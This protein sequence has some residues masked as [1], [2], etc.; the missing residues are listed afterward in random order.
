RFALVF[1][2]L[3]LPPVIN[4]MLFPVDG[5]LYSE[6]IVM[7][8]SHSSPG[9]GG[10]INFAV[11]FIYMIVMAALLLPRAR[12][13][14]RPSQIWLIGLVSYILWSLTIIVVGEAT[15]SWDSFS[16]VPLGINFWAL[17]VY[18]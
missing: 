16:L 10:F 8:S 4:V 13:K 3:F 12:D 15:G 1:K 6:D 9:P 18:V 5:W 17:A 14:H 2:L 7:Y 11:M